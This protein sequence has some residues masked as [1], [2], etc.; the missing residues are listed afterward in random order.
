MR[1]SNA[2]VYLQVVNC[3]KQECHLTCLALNLL[4]HMLQVTLQSLGLMSE[5]GFVV[6]RGSE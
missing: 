2:M 6:D 5:L 4:I 3:R 1:A